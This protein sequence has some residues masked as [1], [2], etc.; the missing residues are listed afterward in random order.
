MKLVLGVVGHIGSL[1]LSTILYCCNAARLEVAMP[2]HSV[3]FIQWLSVSMLSTSHLLPSSLPRKTK[4]NLSQVRESITALES[5]DDQVCIC[6]HELENIT[7][8][9]L[10]T[11]WPWH[12]LRPGK[13]RWCETRGA[14]LSLPLGMLYL[15]GVD[16]CTR[17]VF[18][19]RVCF[20]AAF[21]LL[22]CGLFFEQAVGRRGWESNTH[23]PGTLGL[24][25][26]RHTQNCRGVQEGE[27]SISSHSTL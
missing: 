13:E 3:V 1:S 19:S 11:A 7:Y 15:L 2:G 10:W 26:N 25:P 23:K 27:G 12:Q 24:F 20:S 17:C 22:A 18:I 5:R 21:L 16:L 6:F 4:R 8:Y 9:Q 14:Q